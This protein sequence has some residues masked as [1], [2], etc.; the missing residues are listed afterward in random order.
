MTACGAPSGSL[1]QS[2]KIAPLRLAAS[3]STM[4]L[5]ETRQTDASN[6]SLFARQTDSWVYEDE[7]QTLRILGSFLSIKCMPNISWV[8]LKTGQLNDPMLYAW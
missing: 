2:A 7:T 4:Q 6:G 1:M 8:S 5:H 3:G